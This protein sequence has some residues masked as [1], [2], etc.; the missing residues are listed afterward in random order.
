MALTNIQQV[1]LLV[2]DN[3]PGL[4]I[5]SDDEISYF[6]ERN[7]DNVN[8]A[9]LDVARVILLNLSMRSDSTVDILSL[10]NSKTAEQYRLALQLF[11][12]D[13]NLNPVLNNCQGYFG[14]VSIAD[15]QSNDSTVDNNIVQSPSTTTTYTDTSNYFG[16]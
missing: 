11:L 15:M 2:Q 9:A 6:L 8:K 10:R 3:V 7:Y 16:V 14:N 4:Y 5:V 1:R 12:R 13:P